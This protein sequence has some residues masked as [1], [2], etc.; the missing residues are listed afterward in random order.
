VI[1]HLSPG[2]R[3]R[4]LCEQWKG[5]KTLAKFAA[6]SVVRDMIAAVIQQAREEALEEAAKKIDGMESI[7]KQA[8]RGGGRLYA[9]R[10]DALHEA[11]AAIRSLK[12]ASK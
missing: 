9:A 10:G 6:F 8:A 7:E 5:N 11:A 4:D 12:G 3:A 1:E 2:E